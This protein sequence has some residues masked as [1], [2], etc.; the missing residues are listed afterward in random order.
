MCEQTSPLT[1]S[2]QKAEVPK[3]SVH[4][5]LSP[6]TQADTGFLH[7]SATQPPWVEQPDYSNSRVRRKLSFSS[8]PK[9]Q[10]EKLCADQGWSHIWRLTLDTLQS[11]RCCPQTTDRACVSVLKYSPLCFL[12]FSLHFIFVKCRNHGSKESDTTSKAK[13]K[14]VRITTELKK[15]ITAKF[16]QVLREGG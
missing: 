16:A 12:F 11:K 14:T 1:S 2:M 9:A 3:P 15:G 5:A 10:P 6:Q 4:T 13:G 8:E 7:I